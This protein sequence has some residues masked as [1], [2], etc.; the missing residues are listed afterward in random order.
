VPIPLRLLSVDAQDFGRDRGALARA[1]AAAEVDVACVHGAPHLLRWRSICAAIGR[2]SGLVVV[3]GGRLAGANLLLSSLGVDVAEVAD[4]TFEGGSPLTP[5]GAAL[6]A[7]RLRGAEF[8]LASATLVGNAAER[9]GQARHLQKA[10]DGVVPG[11]PAAVV[12][13]L[14]SDRPGSDA[15]QA[16]VEYRVGVGERIF[17][18]GRVDVCGSTARDGSGI[19]L[20]L[21]LP[22]NG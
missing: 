7:L 19:V 14:G 11:S 10:I 4:L 1:I 22:D 5:S 3:T 18:D 15:W 13:T 17:V 21:E 6:A 12:S 20:D 16:L 8:V 2:Q 9:L